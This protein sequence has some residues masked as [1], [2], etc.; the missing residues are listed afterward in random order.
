MKIINQTKNTILAENAV[1]A[2]TPLAR[3]KGLLARKELKQ[4]EALILKPCNS[5]HMF[6]MRFAIDVIFVDKNNKVVHAVISIKPFRISNIYWRSVLA[7]ELPTGTV[8]SSLTSQG[9]TIL[10]E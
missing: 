9:D 6:F 8:Q 5:I 7:I 1:M 2:Q 4:G 10:L 3:M